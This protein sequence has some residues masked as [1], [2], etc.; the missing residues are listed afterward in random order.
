MVHTTPFVVNLVYTQGQ[1]DGKVAVVMLSMCA[2][3]YIRSRL[4]HTTRQVS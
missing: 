4:M 2:H 3:C 1:I